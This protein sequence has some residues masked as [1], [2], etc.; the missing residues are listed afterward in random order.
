MPILLKSITGLFAGVVMGTV[1][2]AVWLQDE[3]K[4]PGLSAALAAP[5]SVAVATPAALEKPA[6]DKLALAMGAAPLAAAAIPAATPAAWPARSLTLTP[7]EVAFAGPD[8]AALRL[9]AQGLVALAGGDVVE[10]RA[11]LERAAEAGD[12]RALMVLG[13][14][15]DPT[16]L[17]RLGA[18]GIKGDVARAH[19]FYARARE[20]GL[21]GAGPRVASAEISQ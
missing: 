9:R 18:I 8:N 17:A 12:A 13:D 3:T 19:D 16:T 4:T 2:L 5:Q 1:S 6:L 10:A 11:F 15:Y 21:T 7:T 14:T 20:A